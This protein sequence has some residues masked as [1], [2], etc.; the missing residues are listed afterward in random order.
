MRSAQTPVSFFHANRITHTVVK[1]KP[2]PGT[3]YAA[4]YGS[5]RLA[6]CVAAFKPCFDQLFPDHGKFV[7][8]RT[9]Q[10]DALAAGNLGIQIIF[11]SDPADGHQLIR[12][13]F[14][15]GNP[16]YNGIGPAFLNVGQEPVV[17]VLCG[18]IS[19]LQDHFIPKAGKDG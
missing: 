2:A 6:I 13:D 4:F 7:E 12:G 9:E 19:F 1:P 16:G 3:S 8:V 18:I 11:F 10:V 15:S 5:Q 14:S 17:A